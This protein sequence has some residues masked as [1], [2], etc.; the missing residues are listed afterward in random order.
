MRAG[1]RQPVSEAV[2]CQFAS[3]ALVRLLDNPDADR[4]G[5]AVD[6]P[7]TR[8]PREPKPP[9]RPSSCCV[10]L[11]SGSGSSWDRRRGSGR[12]GR[13]PCGSWRSRCRG[14]GGPGGCRGCARCSRCA[15]CARCYR[16]RSAIGVIAGVFW[17]TRTGVFAASTAELGSGVTV[18]M[19]VAVGVGV[20]LCG[21]RRDPP[22]R[23]GQ[24]SCRHET[25]EESPQLQSL[26]S[27]HF[28]LTSG[29][30]IQ[31]SEA[32]FALASHPAKRPIAAGR[33]TASSGI[34]F[35]TTP[36]PTRESVKPPNGTDTS[37]SGQL[38]AR[39]SG[40]PARRPLALAADNC[41][42]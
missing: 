2:S 6:W 4:L 34:F 26:P 15:R 38:R 18:R 5:H 41:C 8:T 29:S 12:D 11:P 16:C 37:H 7:T 9:G 13:S 36:C 33:I 1:R 24:C 10:E 25:D 39:S 31:R 32:G 23:G 40:R 42:R 28:F 3:K 27:G 30:R 21:C 22:R 20:A 35:S 14:R 19:E 17:I